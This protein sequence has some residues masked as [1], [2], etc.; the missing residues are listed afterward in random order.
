MPTDTT[1]IPR[2][3]TR[4][5]FFDV[6]LNHANA[7]DGQIKV[8]AREVVDRKKANDNLPWFVFFQ[9]G[10]GFGS[11][12]PMDDSGWLKRVLQDYRVLLLD[13]RGTGRSTPV[14]Y[15]SLAKLSTPQDQADYLKHF[16]ADSIVRDAE[17]IRKQLL[18]PNEKWTIY[19]QS[20]GGW[21]NTTYLSIAPESLAAVLYTGGLAPIKRHI[22]EVY[23]A[24]Y[25]LVETKNNRFYNRYP[26][27]EPR[28]RDIVDFIAANDVVLPC[29]DPLTP[30]RFQQIGLGF[31]RSTFYETLHY[32]L[33]EAFI[34]GAH[35]REL[36]LKFLR[37]FE[38]QFTFETNPIF[39]LL[40]EAIYTEGPATN[41][42]AHR[43]RDEYPQ[44]HAANDGRV[45]LTGEM[46]YPWMFDEYKHLR[47]LK[48]TVEIL[49]RH[50][51]WSSLY[52][53]GTLAS[54]TVPCA[55]VVYYED[56]CVAREFSL[57]TAESIGNMKVWIT[58][59]YEHDASR[60][61]GNR[62]VGRLL[63]MIDGSVD[64]SF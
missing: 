61:D 9:G 57:E 56:M 10:P 18:G 29:G 12:R 28:I 23:R 41:W 37:D 34:D 8:F 48:D 58:N 54:N 3:I 24:T 49:A 5:H 31:Y 19:G 42:S 59:E 47:P 26:E 16:R 64:F 4:D 22:D 17:L 40:H 43:I 32:M 52:D 63:D 39:C 35:G 62:V 6:P 55:A 13:D 27:D 45:L 14:N 36:G 51:N 53:H 2:L 33:E 11:P 25:K 38:S 60:V 15:Q 46:I 20:Y 30:H 21:C 44:F 50:D 1:A 7:S